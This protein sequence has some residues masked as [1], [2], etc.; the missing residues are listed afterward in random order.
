M[1]EAQR[2][3]YVCS[4]HKL[5][6]KNI[7]D[8]SL[9]EGENQEYV[10]T[11]PFFPTRVIPVDIS[12]HSLRCELVILLE[13]LD[14]TKVPKPKRSAPNK[15]IGCL[16]YGWSKR[17]FDKS[18]GSGRGSFRGQGFRGHKFPM[19]RGNR[20]GRHPH[21][22]LRSPYNKRGF[23]GPP[24]RGRLSPL[25]NYGHTP[26]GPA[27]SEFDSGLNRYSD[28]RRDVENAIDSSY[29]PP[30]GQV[31]KRLAMANAM[32]EQG[33]RLASEV[34]AEDYPMAPGPPPSSAYIRGR[35]SYV[36]MHN[37]SRG[38]GSSWGGNPPPPS[39]SW[40]GGWES[41]DYDMIP[42]GRGSRGLRRPVKVGRGGMRGNSGGPWRR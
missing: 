1:T 9:L 42:P 38:I 27:H 26:Y 17:P 39:A 13:R 7:M 19:T 8:M 31:S 33:I 4:N 20:G 22:L 3:I 28:F 2:I 23:E 40:R 21:P 37:A 25:F 32:L 34:M 35:G 12:P 29:P 41:D 16:Y 36:G 14:M 11:D 10:G 24:R 6:S 5:P 18:R 15:T 30:R